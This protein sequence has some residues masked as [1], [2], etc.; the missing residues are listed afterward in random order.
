VTT[1]CPS[2]GLVNVRVQEIEAAVWVQLTVLLSDARRVPDAYAALTAKEANTQ[3]RLA[4]RTKTLTDLIAKA[5]GRLNRLADALAD[6]EDPDMRAIY[7]EKVATETANIRTWEQERKA[8]EL[9]ATETLAETAEVRDW[10]SEFMTRAVALGEYTTAQ[11]R[12]LATA[13]NLRVAVY[14]PDHE[15]WV[16]MACDLPG[17]EASWHAV[18]SGQLESEEIARSLGLPRR[19]PRLLVPI[20]D[21]TPRVL[22]SAIP[23]R[24]A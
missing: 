7:K 19:S 20:L 13:L 6:E 14:K 21:E 22:T 23:P 2:G 5:R 18:P 24:M 16:E 12:K 1:D 17:I 3:E 11:R 10:M 9:E 15:P 8:V 4:R